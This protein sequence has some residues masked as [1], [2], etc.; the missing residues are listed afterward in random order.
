[1]C[2]AQIT[3]CVSVYLWHYYIQNW[4]LFEIGRCIDQGPRTCNVA[5]VWMS[6]FLDINISGNVVDHSNMVSLRVAGY[7]PRPI[8][9]IFVC[10]QTMFTNHWLSS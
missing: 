6:C 4:A 9:V 3:M 8:W 5:V 2:Q 7:A 1:M 10:L